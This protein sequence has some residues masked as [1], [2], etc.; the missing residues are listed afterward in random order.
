MVLEKT[1]DK[2][3]ELEDRL[4]KNDYWMGE[5]GKS[6]LEA[7]LQ[8]L[9][10]KEM[11][12]SQSPH[13]DENK[14]ELKNLWVKLNKIEAK[15]KCLR[16]QFLDWLSD[17]LLN[18]SNRVHVMA[19][20]IDSPCLIEVAPRKKEESKHARESKEIARLKELL[21]EEREKIKETKI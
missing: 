10:K 12:L 8:S 18:W 1:R 5:D 4:E 21:K 3:K 13:I 16:V 7:R 19:S 11:F 2:I 9:K 14:E 17:K 20:R 6:S 15:E